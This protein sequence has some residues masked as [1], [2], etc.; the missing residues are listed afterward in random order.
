[1]FSAVVSTLD[2]EYW[3][4]HCGNDG[5]LYLLFQRRFLRLTIYLSVISVLSSIIMNL[6]LVPDDDV[7]QSVMSNWF[8]R[9]ALENKRISSYRGWFHVVMMFLNTCLTIRAIQKTRRDARQSY[10]MLHK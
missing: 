7:D 10:Q 8:D 9:T 3:V 2:M 1:M 6:V 4:T 5:Y